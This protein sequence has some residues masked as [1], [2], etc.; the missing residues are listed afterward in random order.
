MSWSFQIPAFTTCFL[1]GNVKKISCKATDPSDVELN[2][3]VLKR[4]C[5][6][7]FINHGTSQ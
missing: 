5:C 6:L 3:E 2:S 1:V 4:V 7:Q